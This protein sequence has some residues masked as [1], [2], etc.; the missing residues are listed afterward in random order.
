MEASTKTGETSYKCKRIQ[1]SINI[2]GVLN[3]PIWPKIEK[4]GR[5]I[6]SDGS[7][8][9]SRQTEARVCW[10][11]KNL[12]IA[13]ECADPDIW[14]TMLNRDD[15]IYDE[16]VVEVFID[17]D[18]DSKEYYEF[19]ISPRNTLFDA[20]IYNP[21]GNQQKG[22]KFHSGIEW[23]YEL[24]GLQVNKEWDCKGIK[25]AVNVN[26]TLDDR[27]D[28]DKVWT[29]EISVPFDSLEQAPHVPPEDGEVWRLNLY[30]IDL[31]P[32]PE[33][34]CWSPT[35][36]VPPDFHVPKAFG[37]LIFSV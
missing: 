3:E 35:L 36:L 10:D 17:P 12:Y 27:T 24:E 37:K 6:L 5:F 16:E 19:E 7:G 31:T 8:V 2:D 22:Y 14:G 4:V 33:F 30:R 1:E 25:T 26:G 28:E 18:C 13:F 11:D 23:D 9:A 21:S 34:S 15:P 32:K 20:R 29:V